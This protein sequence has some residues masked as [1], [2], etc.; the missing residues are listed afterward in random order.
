MKLCNYILIIPIRLYQ[1]ILS[2]FFPNSCRFN[3]T[4]SEYGIQAIQKYGIF[5]GSYLL[6]KRL[7]RCNP[8]GGHGHDPVP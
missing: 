4:C 8:W 3:P 6:V 1:R 7:L 2:P 5:K